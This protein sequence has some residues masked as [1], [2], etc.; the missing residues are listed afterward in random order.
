MAFHY[1]R[2]PIDIALGA[3]GGP[4]R[5]T[6]VVSLVSGA[7][8]RN[9]LWAASRRY[10]NAGYG[11]KSLAD[12]REVLEFFE[13][14][15]GRFHSFLWRDGFDFSTAPVGSPVT[16][17][18]QLIGTGDGVTTEFQLV[19][20]YGGSF[21]PYDRP[22]TKPDPATLVVALDG[23]PVPSSDFLVDALSGIITF[24]IAPS[25]S[26]VITAGFEFDIVVRFDSDQLDVE[27]SSFDAASIPNIMVVEVLE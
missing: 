17:S 26:A 12:M 4:R 10:F 25:V 21:D 23:V 2:F 24:N 22:I 8:E 16:A 19:K 1:I 9:S 15:R 6:D 27:L 14:R 7:E 20:R 13:E 18:D 5:K 11:V 3:R